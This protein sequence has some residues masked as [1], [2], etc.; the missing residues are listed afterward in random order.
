MNTPF[1]P[2]FRARLAACRRRLCVRR[3]H[4]LHRLETL[5]AHYLPPGLLAPAEEGPNSRQRVFCRRRTFWG[6]LYQVLH[7]GCAC[8][9]VVRQV[10]A[11][12]DLE[13]HGP[14]IDEN[15]SAYCQARF[16]LPLDTL[17]RIR[18][19]VAAHAVRRLPAAQQLW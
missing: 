8:R 12:V 13:G 4:H 7:P 1:F 17:Q 5:F 18:H 10:Q 6:F 2:A 16:R 9:Q 14:R 15:T 11:L 19:G 3:Q